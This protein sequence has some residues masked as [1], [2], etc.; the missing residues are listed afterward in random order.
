MRTPI[1]T[2]PIRLPRLPRILA[3]V[4]AMLAL[5]ERRV[6]R[7]AHRRAVQRRLQTGLGPEDQPA[8]DRHDA[9]LL[10]LLVDRGVGQSLR[11]PPLGQDRPP[12][13]PGKALSDWHT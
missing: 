8:F 12:A 3:A 1:L 2:E 11:Q 7:P 10:P 6:D 5:H 9:V 4:G 13:R